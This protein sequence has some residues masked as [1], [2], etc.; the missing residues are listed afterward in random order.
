LFIYNVIINKL[1]CI[2]KTLTV[3]R[4][5]LQAAAYLLIF[6]REKNGTQT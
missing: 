6:R 3:M 5:P 2:L 1:N 4:T